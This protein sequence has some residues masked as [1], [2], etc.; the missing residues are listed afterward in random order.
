MMGTGIPLN[1]AARHFASGFKSYSTYRWGDRSKLSAD[2]RAVFEFILLSDV[3]L[4]P[5][6]EDDK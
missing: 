1:K 5:F 3:K 6:Y 4:T 2:D